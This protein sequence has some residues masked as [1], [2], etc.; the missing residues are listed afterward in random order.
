M[1][2]TLRFLHKFN[3]LYV[4]GPFYPNHNDEETVQ[5]SNP[6][7]MTASVLLKSSYLGGV[8][9]KILPSLMVN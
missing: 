7:P 5:V 2:D 8:E 6:N 1:T 9:T 4:K 3:N